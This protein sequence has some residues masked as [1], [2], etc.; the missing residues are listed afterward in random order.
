MT[1]LRPWLHRSMTL[2]DEK[3]M[4][5]TFGRL[6]RHRRTIRFLEDSA[7]M[8]PHKLGVHHGLSFVIGSASQLDRLLDPEDDSVTLAILR[9]G[10]HSWLGSAARTSLARFRGLHAKRAPPTR[11]TESRC[12]DSDDCTTWSV[13]LSL[14]AHAKERDHGATCS[15]QSAG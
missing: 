14:I 1:H 11:S 10:H 4:R 6:S 9:R 5:S 13:A 12:S 7:N 15:S 8:W 2:T 3:T